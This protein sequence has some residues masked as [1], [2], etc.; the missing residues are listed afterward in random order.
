MRKLLSL[1]IVAFVSI[2]VLVGCSQ[3]S[4]VLQP[5]VG[6]WSVTTLGI[7]TTVVF[8][9]DATTVETTTVLGI[10]VTKTGTW[11]SNDTTITRTWSDGSTNVKY[12]TFADSNNQLVLSD[13]ADGVAI[14]YT[15][16]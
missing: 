13:S 3:D 15:R 11:T 14:T 4:S 9:N 1:A 10:S 5:I 8:N 7:P 2:A 6:T 12:Y 16:Q